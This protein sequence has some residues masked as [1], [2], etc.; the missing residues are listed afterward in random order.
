MDGWVN[1]WVDTR[2]VDRWMSGWVERRKNRRTG[3]WKS[4]RVNGGRLCGHID[5]RWVRVDG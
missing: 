1:G 3:E 4:G 5:G 2:G